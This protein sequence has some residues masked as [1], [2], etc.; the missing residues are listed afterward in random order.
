MQKDNFIF[1]GTPRFAEIFL[2]EIIQFGFV[3]RAVITNPD[4][5]TG[6]KKIITPPLIKTLAEE[7]DIPVFQNKPETFNIELGVSFGLVAA[8][9]RIIP[10]SVIRL[11]PKGI[12]CAHPSL[13]PELRGATPIQTALLENRKETGTTLFLLD[14][15]VDHGAIL[16]Q[17]KI[18]I[19]ENDDYASL[20]EKLAK[21][22]AKLF[23]ETIGKYIA[24]EI[25]PILQNEGEVTLTKKFSRDD[26]FISEE[27]LLNAIAG[28]SAEKVFGKIRAFQT[29]PGA[30][31]IKNGKQ[32]KLLA[33]VLEN[34]KLRLTRVQYE[35]KKPQA[36]SSKESLS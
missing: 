3:P 31:T 9:G 7:N 2:R 10:D 5:P 25:K 35:G 12:L 28:K 32:I 11:F 13:L 1:F 6:R 29:E 20:E 8:Y 23:S 36:L 30:W 16:A 21:L 14:K 19:M 34:G 24:G 4:K 33:A 22:S 15:F 27:D 18:T 26:A 17:E